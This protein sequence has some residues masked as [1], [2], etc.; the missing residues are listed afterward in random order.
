V[1]NIDEVILG[2]NILRKYSDVIH[3]QSFVLIAG[4]ESYEEISQTDRKELENHHWLYDEDLG[5]SIRI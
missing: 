1:K 3:T 4:P 2:L 5:W